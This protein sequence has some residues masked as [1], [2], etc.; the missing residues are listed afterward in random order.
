MNDIKIKDIKYNFNNNICSK[1]NSFIKID[2]NN[3]SIKGNS[4]ENKDK[5]NNYF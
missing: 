3:D 4:I 2:I 5:S 1:N